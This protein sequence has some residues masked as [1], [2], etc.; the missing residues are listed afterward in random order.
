MFKRAEPRVKLSCPPFWDVHVGAGRGR[1]EGWGAHDPRSAL[2]SRRE[3]R[4]DS[5]APLFRVV[6]RDLHE[7]EW[8]SVRIVEVHPPPSGE[9]TLVDDIDRAVELDALRLEFGLLRLDVVDEE[10]DMGG[11]SVVRL[12]WHRGLAWRI[13]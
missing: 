4:R 1:L 8:V 12:E 7:F 9:H 2:R 11:S 13:L 6:V 3:I 10:G 5:G